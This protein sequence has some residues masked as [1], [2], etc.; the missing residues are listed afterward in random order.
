HQFFTS[1]Y[2]LVTLREDMLKR[3]GQVYTQIVKACLAREL[4]PIIRNLSDMSKTEFY[5]DC[6]AIYDGLVD[7]LLRAT[8]S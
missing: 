5:S 6:L 4:L 8:H 7:F 3:N 1:C 2:T